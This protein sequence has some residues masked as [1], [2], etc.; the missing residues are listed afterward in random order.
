MPGGGL[1]GDGLPKSYSK[2]TFVLAPLWMIIW[3]CEPAVSTVGDFAGPVAGGWGGD[4][5]SMSLSTVPSPSGKDE[6]F[7]KFCRNLGVQGLLSI[8]PVACWCS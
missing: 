1:I 5:Y 6:I 7:I 4:S 2:I 3:K 8:F